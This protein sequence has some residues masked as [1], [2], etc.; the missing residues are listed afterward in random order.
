MDMRA[1]VRAKR[2]AKAA[3]A[4]LRLCVEAA[5]KIWA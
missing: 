2:L 4:K 1:G 3:R 5:E